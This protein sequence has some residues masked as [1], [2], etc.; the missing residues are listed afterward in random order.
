M[1]GPTKYVYDTCAAVFL[2]NKNE[3]MLS[4]QQ[5]LESEEKYVSVITRM[6]LRAKPGITKGELEEIK[7]LLMDT[8]VIP[9]DEAVEE[10]AVKIRREIKPK[11]KLPDCIVAATAIVLG[12]TLLTGDTQLKALVWPGYTEQPL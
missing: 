10:I 2:L 11:I 5:D 3:R 12:A 6:E 7:N 9:L 1:N 4:I 8:A